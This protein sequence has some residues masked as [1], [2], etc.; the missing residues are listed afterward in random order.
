MDPVQ[1]LVAPRMVFVDVL[2]QAEDDP[3]FEADRRRQRP[4]YLAGVYRAE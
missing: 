4:N 3:V 2:T 1:V